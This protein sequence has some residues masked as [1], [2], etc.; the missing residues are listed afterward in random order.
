MQEVQS[1]IYKG[2]FVTTR[3]T[4]HDPPRDGL[5]RVFSASFAVEPPDPCRASWQQFPRAVFGTLVA[6]MANAMLGA[7]RSIDQDIYESG[8]WGLRSP[9]PRK[10]HGRDT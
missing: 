8:G 3:W 9:T 10:G 5:A 2:Y 1:S 6:A 4:A 7:M